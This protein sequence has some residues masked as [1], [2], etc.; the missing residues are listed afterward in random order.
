M[1]SIPCTT[2]HLNF[3]SKHSNSSSPSPKFSSQFLGTKSSLQCFRTFKIGPSNGS[4]TKC[5]FKFG[6]NGVDAE[7]AGIY[8]SQ[9]RDDF[10]RD[11]VEQ[12]LPLSLFTCTFL[13]VFRYSISAFIFSFLVGVW[14]LY[15]NL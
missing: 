11:D 3:I 5:W 4:K 1:A 14:F 7:N 13:C 6:K 2:T 10:D 8:G 9:T 15:V 12:V